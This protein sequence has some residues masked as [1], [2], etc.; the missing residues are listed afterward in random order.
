MCDAFGKLA[1][2]LEGCEGVLGFEVS[3]SWYRSFFF[4]VHWSLT[5]HPCDTQPMNE[6]HRGY[7][8]LHSMYS[9]DP[10]TDLQLG[11][12]TSAL[13][14]FA[15][16]D[17]YPQLIPYYIPTFPQPTKVSH[18][19]MVNE[20]RHRAWQPDK[21]CIWREH[22]VWQWDEK[23]GKAIPLR[24]NYFDK[25]PR[26]GKPFEWYKDAWYP[27]I[28]RFRQA[29]VKNKDAR[30]TWMTFAAGI[31]NEVSEWSLSTEESIRSAPMY[32]LHTS[33]PDLV[34]MG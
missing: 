16:G 24:L 27:F 17:G 1:D 26:T 5:A 15:I 10:N 25:D 34:S 3:G 20:E 23:A 32:G 28:K 14:S 29:V 11:F 2:A 6:P 31:P 19:V 4:A 22:G 18:H 8:E 33:L 30:R 12:H 13:E 7:L 21:P 9:F